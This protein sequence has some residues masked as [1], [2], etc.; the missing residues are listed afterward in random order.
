MSKQA[1]RK[2]VDSN[3]VEVRT[4]LFI[5]VPLALLAAAA[6][7]GHIKTSADPT[8]TAGMP[9]VLDHFFNIL[10][11]AGMFALFFAVGRR[12][13]N[14]CGFEWN[15]FAEEGAFST[16]TGAAVIALLILAAAL[17]DVL[18]PYVV[19]IIFLAALILCGSQL[20]RLIEVARTAMSRDYSRPLE[21]AYILAFAAIVLVMVLRALTPPHAVD[22]AI[23]H[24]AA[25][26]RF[27]EA[28]SL[29]PLYDIAQ[30]NTHM[31]AHML[32][33]PC[34]MLGA[35]SAAKLLSVGFALVTALSLFAYARRFF[36]EATGYVAALGFF[37]AGMVVEVAIT[38]RI[39]VI[40][41]GFLFLATYSLTV[42]L[43]DR[44]TRWLWLSAVLSGVAVSIKL[45][46]L[47]WVAILGCVYLIQTLPRASIQE[48]FLH[49][50]RGVLYFLILLAVISPWLLKNYV[51]FRDPFYPFAHGETVTGERSEPIAYFGE[52]EEAKLESYFQK[53][54][55]R[56][57]QVAQRIGEILGQAAANRPE[58]H[59]L[60]FWGYFTNPTVYN[61]GEPDHTPNY[62]FLLCPLF[63]IF[64]RDRRMVW[65]AISCV[66]FFILMAWA[67]WTARYLL[68]LYPP[69]T[70]IAAYTLVRM[71][72]W[73]KRKS[74]AAVALPI[75]AL[76]LTTGVT[77]FWETSQLIRMFELN[78][79]N[80]S[81]SRADYLSLV[82]YYPALRYVNENV[83]NDAKILMMGS[84][85]GYD[86]QRPY[87]GDT[88]WEATPWRRL[89]LKADSPEGV[90]DAM[91]AQGITHVMYAPELF[92][93]A[94]GTGTLS[95]AA[96]ES[97]GAARPDYYEQLRNW[98]TFED[99]KAKFLELVY[100]DE[101]SR[102]AVYVLR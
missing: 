7:Y 22:E 39:D 93:F 1:G 92:V 78:Y 51:Y 70:V 73:L 21:V 20:L 46:G 96:H 26:K 9:L 83:S 77:V 48:L 85:M 60:R 33:A 52:P 95:I 101:D 91:K 82:F 16:A 35:D 4:L 49:L 90:R 10:V 74:G 17:A 87:V 44:K 100:K 65:L 29:T 97:K 69:L 6:I 13:L 71:T 66:V 2:A 79:V 8:H 62:L 40:L 81:L 32:F 54:R 47:L 84:Q 36:G 42:Y 89:L 25:V 12:L 63:L 88:T 58:R 80:G 19:G 23:Y 15:S 41:A 102:Y 55:E 94:T 64:G 28:G 43:E 31:L 45:T 38:A 61:V 27:I 37:G 5:A 98:T 67:A 24:L 75:I 72:E 34:L 30:G 50:R 11:A 56:N 68:P 14:L 59:P 57:P 3:P 76:L 99:F 18:N 53:A 86:L